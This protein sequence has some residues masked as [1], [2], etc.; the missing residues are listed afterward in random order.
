MGEFSNFRREYGKLSLSDHEAAANPF[1]QFEKWMKE[2]VAAGIEEPNAMALATVS[3]KGFPSVR[4]L[5]LKEFNNNGFVFFTSY[6]S[7]KGRHLQYQPE[8]SLLFFWPELERQI[9]IEGHVEKLTAEASDAY[10]ITRPPESRAAAHLSAQSKKLESREKL[11]SAVA[12]FM[13]HHPEGPEQRPEHWGGYLLTPQYFEFW[14]G[15]LNGLHD[16]IVYCPNENGWKK[17]RLF[18]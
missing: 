18:P 11:E 4:M 7:R 17:R 15:R 8:A 13:R 14:Q 6:E 5:L 12:D 16:R 10:F 9:R 3:E 2:A 1:D